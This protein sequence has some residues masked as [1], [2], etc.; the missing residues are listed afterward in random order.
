[1][2][3]TLIIMPV[4]PQIVPHKDKAIIAI[5]GL[6]FMLFPMSFGSKI[7]PVK[8][9]IRPIQ[10]RTMLK[11]KN[12]PNCSKQ[13]KAG[14]KVPKTEPTVGMKFKMKIKKAQN[15]G[16]STPTNNRTTKLNVPV[17]RLVKVFKPR[18]FATE[19]SILSIKLITS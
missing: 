11:G 4:T 8:T 17:I 9:C 5:S 6:M 10:K 14:N 13:K 16:E 1:M 3:G 18:Y 12:A 7:L 19:I 15:R 2:I